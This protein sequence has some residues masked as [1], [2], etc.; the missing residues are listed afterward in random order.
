MYKEV[1]LMNVFDYF[2]ESTHQLKK[3]FVLNPKQ[4]IAFD[5]LYEDSLKMA[6]HLDESIGSGQNVLIICPNFVFFLTAYLGVLKSG[7]ACVPLNFT[8]EQDNLD[9][10]LDTT[11][12][13]LVF[14]SKAIK[15]KLNFPE[16]VVL[17]D[18]DTSK[19]IIQNQPINTFPSNFDSEQLAEIIFTSGSTGKPKGVMLS[20][21]N[22]IANTNSIIEYL[23]LTSKDIMLVVLPFFYCYGL[24]LLHTHLRVGGSIVLNNSFIFLG[25]VI[26]DLKNYKCTGFA[27]VPSHFQILLKKS[28]TFKTT[29]FPDLKYV[30]QAGGKLHAIFIKEF[31]NAFPDIDF[32]VMYGQT[33]ATARLS[34][35]PLDVLKTKTASIG[36]GIPGVELKVIDKKGQPVTV[37]E[38]GELLAKGDNVMMGYYKDVDSTKQTIIDGWLHTGD[39]AKMDDDGYLY[40]VARKKEI[41][42]VGGKRVSPKEIE[43]V[44]LSV[45][46]VVD[47]T[48]VGVEDDIL[49]EALEATIVLN[50]KQDEAQIKETILKACSRKLAHY[51]IPQKFVFDTN[52][53]MSLT[54]KC[55]W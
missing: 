39:M 13:Q 48:I 32:Y 4:A 11:E 17:I 30:T 8:I 18:E 55:R 44:I 51:K 37:D 36:K 38:E 25:S 1:L 10:I 33:E 43:E 42:K 41:I 5:V 47:C 46:E 12:C 29:E 45:P 14:V 31:I 28:K 9:Y 3:D 16:N 19:D 35:L 2:F 26:N 52:F 54:G 27:G 50:E 40:L 24:S 21:K 53:I 7:N 23:K 22:I 15:R 49:G 34:Y 20:H 6:S